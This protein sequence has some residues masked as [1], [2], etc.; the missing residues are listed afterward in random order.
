MLATHDLEWLA[1]M[2]D[3]SL[4]LEAAGYDLDPWQRDM[5]RSTDARSLVLAARQVGKSLTAA[6]L[7]LHAALFEPGSLI[8][9]VSPSLRQSGEL[10]R[11]VVG[12]L[13]A[14]G[15]PVGATQ[16]SVTSLQLANRSRIV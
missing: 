10:Y 6:A 14:L 2:L 1:W 9:L 3:P 12:L 11:K 8:L 13:D 7:G 4:I 16:E 15:R 5:L